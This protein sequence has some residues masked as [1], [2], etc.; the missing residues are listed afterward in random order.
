MGVECG[1]WNVPE[2]HPARRFIVLKTIRDVTKLVW[3]Q[4][5]LHRRCDT[6]IHRQMRKGR[7]KGYYGKA[8]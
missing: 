7:Q 6:I 8:K 2:A 3:T 5:N 1:V 4:E